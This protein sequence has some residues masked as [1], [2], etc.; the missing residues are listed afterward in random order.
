MKP[1]WYLAKESNVFR[2]A[3]RKILSKG[4]HRSREPTDGTEFSTF[5]EHIGGLCGYKSEHDCKWEMKREG[6]DRPQACRAW[7]KKKK[8]KTY[9]ERF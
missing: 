4:D 9:T 2:R 3:R 6:R 1:W 7:C 5:K 8:N